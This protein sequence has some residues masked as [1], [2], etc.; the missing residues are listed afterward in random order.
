MSNRIE[1]L[2]AT[3]NSAD[4]LQDMLDSLAAQS[5]DDFHLVVSD[6]CS[7]DATVQIVASMS[8]RFRNPVEIIERQTPSGSA[9]ANFAALLAQSRGDYVFLCDHDDLWR[10]GKIQA[11][12]DQIRGAEDHSG[13]DTPIL[14]HSDLEVIDAQGNTIH[15]SYWA[16]KKISADAG[17]NLPQAL[18]HATVTG[19][20]AAM[21]RAMVAQ[22][23]GIP[24]DAIMHDWWINLV[25]AATGQVICD[26]V[27]HIGY[28]IHGNNVS[29]PR[30]ISPLAALGQFDK[31]K[32][33][34]M[35]FRRRYAQGRALRDHLDGRLSPEK[36]GQLERFA[37]IPGV[38]FGVRQLALVRGGFLWPGVW[39]NIVQL[40]FA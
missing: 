11:A 34:R 17:R 19:C 6:D 39:R 3:Y 27:A 33:A 32:R 1:V 36:Q 26:P 40:P 4:Y 15:P 7:S 14:Y 10:P 20:A 23:G 25:A 12:L 24:N 38:P 28:R 30:E 2:L 21:N 5:F 16:F 29:A 22:L 35:N 37:H 18:V 9:S 8:D 31:L 13:V